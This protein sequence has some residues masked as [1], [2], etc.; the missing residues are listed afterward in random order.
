VTRF[1][2]ESLQAREPFFRL[3]L[4]SLEAANSNP[5]TDIRFSTQVR[6]ATQDKLRALG[7]DP[8]DTTPEELYHVLQER[9]KDDD[10]RLT[11]RLRTTA[12]THVSAEGEMVSGMV[13]VL[14]RLPDSKHCFAMKNSTLRTILKALPPKKAMK[15]LGYRSVDSFLK[16]EAPVSALAA[17]WLCEGSS[18]QHRLL[19]QYKQLRPGDFESR[20]IIITQPDSKHWRELASNIVGQRKHNLLCFKEL[21]ALVFLPLP[22]EIPA[23]AATASLSLALY[24]L[25]QIRASSTFLKLCQV[26]P[27]FGNLVRTVASDEPE[28]QTRLLDQPVSWQLIQRYYL[29]LAEQFREEIFG[30]HIR[31][32]DMAWHPIEHTLST[33]EPSFDFWKDSSYLG[34]LH[35]RQPVSLNI[36]DV[37][38]SYCNKL[39]F[40]QRVARYFRQSLWHELLLQYLNHDTVEQTVMTA[41]QPEL[42]QKT[43]LEAVMA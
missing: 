26:R 35:Q 5:N 31:L 15:Q 3:G 1:L 4:R 10:A 20:S 32:E 25:N 43:A 19:E 7:L 40:E 17:A 2:S 24:E 8:H 11:K 41:L 39:P 28:L 29:R 34:V 12:A 22:A 37:A 42:A 33:I 6:R 27:D 30:P 16:H 36:V 14:R 38:L 13:H 23:G 18:W 21:G 9:M